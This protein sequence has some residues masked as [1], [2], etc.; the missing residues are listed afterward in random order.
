MTS[1]ASW[2]SQRGRT[3]ALPAYAFPLLL[4]LLCL[5][6]PASATLTSIATRPESPREC[7]LIELVVTGTTPTPCYSIV[8]A[9]LEGPVP[10]P[11]MGP[12]PTYE[13]KVRLVLQE[14]PSPDIGACPQVIQ[15]YRKAFEL[16]RLPFGTYWVRAVEEV[17]AAGGAPR[18]SSSLDSMFQVSM[19]GACLFTEPCFYGFSFVGTP[20]VPATRLGPCGGGA[21]PGGTACAT[22]YMASGLAVSG[23]QMVVDVLPPDGYGSPVPGIQAVSVEAV[24]AAE[25]FQVTWSAQGSRTRILLYSA[26]GDTIPYGERRVVRICYA[27][28]SDVRP[29]AY[30]VQVHDV[31]ASDPR[32]HEIPKCDEYREDA[33]RICVTGPT[34]DLNGDGRSDIRD[35][36]RVANCALEASECPDSVA[37]HA[38]CNGDGTVDVRDVV[39]CVRRLLE[40]DQAPLILSEDF[41]GEPTRLRFEG[42]ARWLEPRKGIVEVQITPGTTFGGLDFWFSAANA[43]ARITGIRLAPGS[44][45]QLQSRVTGSGESA[46]AVLLPMGDAFPSTTVWIDL[47]PTSAGGGGFIEMVGPESVTRQARWMP[48]LIEGGITTAVPE[49]VAPK[50]PTVESTRPNPFREETEI[51]YTLPSAARATLRVYDASGRLVRTLFEADMS[52]GV[53]RA[54][55]DGRDASDRKVGSGIYFFQLAANGATS[56]SRILLLR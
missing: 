42:S 11:T 32:G 41:N 16:G 33:G 31:I 34:C 50:A 36:V 12:I 6:S 44:G 46:R 5:P 49:T 22:L 54:R 18:D 26:Q 39:C 9:E 56:T 45:Y 43:G 1:R 40:A 51:T 3:Q 24:G 30:P 28:R 13:I 38:D 27:I 23:V 55:W 37:V 35:I 52:A 14:T 15:E 8:R 17:L 21:P 20:D 2:S 47:V 10:L 48:S 25:G 19:S 7:D 29:E 4:A 53:H